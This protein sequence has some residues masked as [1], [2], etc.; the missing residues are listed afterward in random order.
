MKTWMKDAII[1]TEKTS[2]CIFASVPDEFSGY[3]RRIPRRGARNV[4]SRQ[5]TRSAYS[6]LLLP[7]GYLQFREGVG[8][9]PVIGGWGKGTNQ[10]R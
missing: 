6:Q 8:K 5:G 3:Q 1:A 10:M 4:S 9:W 2:W 7:S